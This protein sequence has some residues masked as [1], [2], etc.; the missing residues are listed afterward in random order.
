MPVM[1]TWMMRDSGWRWQQVNGS[2]R[3]QVAGKG[4]EEERCCTPQQQNPGQEA[5]RRT[6]PASQG[7]LRPSRGLMR[8]CVRTQTHTHTHAR[9]HARTHN[10]AHTAAHPSMASA[11]APTV[12]SVASTRNRLKGPS[13]KKPAVASRAICGA[14]RRSSAAHE[15]GGWAPPSH[16][17]FGAAGTSHHGLRLLAT[18]CS[19]C[20]DGAARGGLPCC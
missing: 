18:S 7:I 20:G 19:S 9:A 1:C 3:G 6:Q 4:E 17:R 12:S 10:F 5:G 16:P 11:S 2:T 15:V 14:A 13:V 8:A